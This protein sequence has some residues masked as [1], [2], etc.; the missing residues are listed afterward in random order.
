MVVGIK[1][2]LIRNIA[3]MITALGMIGTASA[4]QGFDLQGHRGARGL[5]P[6]N[7]LHGFAKALEIGVTTLE[8]DVGVT[9]DDTVVVIHNSRLEPEIARAA[10]GEW[11]RESGPAVNSLTLSEIKTFDVG[12]LNPEE[13]YGKRYPDQ[14][15]VDGARVPTLAEVFDLVNK[16]GNS[17]VRFNIE[18]KLNPDRPELS[19]APEQF[20]TKVIDV[21]RKYKF[22][23]R[24][25]FQSF[26]WRTLQAAQRIAPE[27]TTSYL[28]VNQSWLN[29]LQT[30][31]PGA[32][33]WLAGFDIDDYDGS[34]PHAIKAAGGSV[35]SSYHKEVTTKSID[36]AHKLGLRVKVWTV[37][38][39]P[40][41][42]ELIDM[43][44]DGI[45]TD[46]PNL[47]REVLVEREIEVP[48]S[49][50]VTP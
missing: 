41:M 46:F 30:G 17:K 14:V 8:L 32:S 44:V 24:V 13:R 31:Q 37:N 21:I 1:K 45:I 43:G 15:A 4:E 35:W 20:A 12:R 50:P 5:A 48:P 27:I 3:T 38:D 19:L 10:N 29:N 11:L 16:S 36:T 7:T 28:S 40:R 33:P 42:E 26:D 39:K 49:T 2:Q 25:T 6:E 34:T 22:E 18:S 9:K 47:L 23:D